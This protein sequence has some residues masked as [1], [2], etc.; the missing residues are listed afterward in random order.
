MGE[1]TEAPPLNRSVADSGGVTTARKCGG[2]ELLLV[3]VP[4]LPNVST[5]LGGHHVPYL[6]PNAW[7]PLTSLTP[8]DVSIADNLVLTAFGNGVR[9]PSKFGG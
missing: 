1:A 3:S 9:M 4:A 6:K 7:G 8:C 2:S 5:L